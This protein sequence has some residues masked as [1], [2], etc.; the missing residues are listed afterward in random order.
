[1][2]LL[3]SFATV[4]ARCC[5]FAEVTAR[6]CYLAEVSDVTSREPLESLL[7]HVGCGSRGEPLEPLERFKWEQ[8]T[9]SSLETHRIDTQRSV[10][11]R[12]RQQIVAT[13]VVCTRVVTTA[14]GLFRRM[15]EILRIA[16]PRGTR[17]V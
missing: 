13:A 1:M 14:S 11:Q 3:P 15:L 17:S 16:S 12:Q 10:C 6:C 9:S 4:T 8:F 2:R 7:G 5:D